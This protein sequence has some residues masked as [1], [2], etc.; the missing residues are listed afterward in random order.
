MFI[1]TKAI[2]MCNNFHF[3]TIFIQKDFE[4]MIIMK[5]I[6]AVA[7]MAILLLTGCGQIDE[8][9]GTEQ[10]ANSQTTNNHEK[11]CYKD[12]DRRNRR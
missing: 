3:L 4:R 2:I 8:K 9:A 5:K 6:I 12:Q 1:M 10:G 7:F 11:N